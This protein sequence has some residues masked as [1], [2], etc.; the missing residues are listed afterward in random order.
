MS[1]V[2]LPQ[3]SKNTSIHDWRSAY[4]SAKALWL[5]AIAASDYVAQSV[6]IRAHSPRHLH[7]GAGASNFGTPLVNPAFIQLVSVALGRFQ[8]HPAPFLERMHLTADQIAMLLD[9]AVQDSSTS[10]VFTVLDSMRPRCVGAISLLDI[11]DDVLEPILGKPNIVFD[12]G[13]RYWWFSTAPSEIF[14]DGAVLCIKATSNGVRVGLVD[15]DPSNISGGSKFLKSP[16]I[17]NEIGLNYFHLSLWGQ[18][19]NET[20]PHLAVPAW[21]IR[22][23]I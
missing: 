8:A 4:A 11:P 12:G 18:V 22:E 23:K 3:E 20:G 14:H 7:G 19:E 6:S 17:D 9:A 5:K 16:S 1:T 10:S 13:G 15:V 21:M 2:L